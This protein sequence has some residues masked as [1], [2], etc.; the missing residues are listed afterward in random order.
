MILK[1]LDDSEDAFL[2][3]GRRFARRKGHDDR[4]RFDSDSDS[5][6]KRRQDIGLG[7]NYRLPC[8]EPRSSLG[9]SVPS[10]HAILSRD[11]RALPSDPSSLR[12]EATRDKKL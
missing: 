1:V 5:D 7:P 8:P 4:R 3:G 6:K 10:S 2:L 12:P 11:Y 9:T